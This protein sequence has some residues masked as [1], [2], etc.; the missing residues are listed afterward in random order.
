MVTAI[1]YTF[2]MGIILLIITTWEIDGKDKIPNTIIVTKP[3]FYSSL[4]SQYA[5]LKVDYGTAELG[6][7]IL[8]FDF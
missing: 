1:I 3:A 8:S 2:M 6:L 4:I 7:L 5:N